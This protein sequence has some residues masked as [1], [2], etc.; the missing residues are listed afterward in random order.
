MRRI[1]GYIYDF[2]ESKIQPPKDLA[3]VILIRALY[4]NVKKITNQDIIDNYDLNNQDVKAVIKK[5]LLDNKEKY[6]PYDWA[7][8]QELLDLVK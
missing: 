8:R 4:L 1:D 6:A 2:A 7:V 5:I 3:M